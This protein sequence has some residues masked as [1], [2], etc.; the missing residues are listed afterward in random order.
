MSDP[1]QMRH[2]RHIH[3]TGIG[4]SGM[5]GIAEVLL[6][7]GFQ[8]TG[9]DLEE[10]QNTKRL[11]RLGVTV[12]HEHAARNI[13]NADVVVTSSA[14]ANDNIELSTARD[15]YVPVISRA[16]MLGEL[17]RHRY[18]IA[19]AGTHGKTTTTS[20]I[21]SIFQAA[22]LDPTYVIGGLLKSEGKN[23]GLGLSKYMIA[24][25]DESDA[26][27]LYLK[28]MLAVITNIDHDHMET[29]DHDF[30]LLRSTFEEFVTRLP[31]YGAIVVCIDDP[32]AK[33]LADGTT[34]P[35]LT[36]GLSA[37]ADFRALD[38]KPNESEWKFRCLRPA[39][40]ATLDITLS[41]PGTQNVRNALAAIAVA[42]DEGIGDEN[43]IE[44]IATFRGVGRRFEVSRL[45]IQE[46]EIVLVDDYGHHPT[47][48]A[49]VIETARKIWFSRRIMMVYQPH[50]FTRTRD[51]FHEFVDVLASVDE[52]HLL[53]TYGAGEKPIDGADVSTLARFIEK[54][55][56]KHVSVYTNQ[57]DVVQKLIPGLTNG[58]VLMIQGAGNV[59]GVSDILKSKFSNH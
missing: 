57:N 53:E 55:H 52:L 37:S 29:Y 36:Y 41:L 25:A 17:M 11:A 22:G 18:G 44:G 39:G 32:E 8:V 31:F 26:S 13:K 20:L 4:G 42:T 49:Y 35:V 16:E 30:D 21:T 3:L 56:G 19:I 23:A 1:P 47:E 27:F 12:Y 59:S 34:R 50:R 54:L 5:C 15:R 9:S 51:L 43:I 48:L 58:D 38:L 24:E 14:I 10:S 28:P 2:V 33:R 45:L 7:Q 6:N 40:Y 46:K